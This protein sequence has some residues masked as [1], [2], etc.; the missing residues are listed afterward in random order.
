MRAWQVALVVG[1]LGLLTLFYKGLWG[2]PAF[3]P[4]V[5]VGTAAPDFTGPELYK[6]RQVSLNDFSGKVVVVNFWASWCLEC[7]QEHPSL[8]ALADRFGKDPKFVMIGVNY[9]DREEDA[10][11]YLEEH[12]DAFIHIR[13]PK[14]TIS[15]DY[16]VYGIPETFIIDQQGIIRHKLIG[17][18]IGDVYTNIAD[19]IIQPLLEGKPLRA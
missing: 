12:G 17:P 19:R 3:I 2:N 7:K 16:G 14:G 5:L 8:L 13:D 1:V 11:K 4:S 15:I 18:I 6:G 10:K 9:Q